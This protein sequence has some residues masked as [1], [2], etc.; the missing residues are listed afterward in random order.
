[1][2]TITRSARTHSIAHV[3]GFQSRLRSL[4]IVSMI[5]AYFGHVNPM[6]NEAWTVVSITPIAASKDIPAHVELASTNSICGS[7]E[8]HAL[9]DW[10]DLLT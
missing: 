10:V 6:A 2:Q 4:Y 8:V 1:M 7:S 5:I 9:D 3:S